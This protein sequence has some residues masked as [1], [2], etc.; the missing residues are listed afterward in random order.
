MVVVVGK[1]EGVVQNPVFLLAS[2]SVE[3]GRVR[4]KLKALVCF[5]TDR[6]T[7]LTIVS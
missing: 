7:E 1:E 4:G 6:V 5:V 3:E 2:A